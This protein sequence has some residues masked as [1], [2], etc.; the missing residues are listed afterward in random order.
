MAVPRLRRRR[1][2]R[3]P[4][5][6]PGHP[7]RSDRRRP[8]MELK[9]TLHINF[10]T[11][12]AAIK[13][14]FKPE[15]EKAAAFIR[16]HANVPYVVISGYTDSQ[17]PSPTINS[18]RNVAPSSPPELI[19]NYGV[20]ESKIR[21]KGFGESNPIADNGTPEG[22]SQN[23]RVEVSC[24]SVLPPITRL[25]K[26]EGPSFRGPSVTLCGTQNAF[27]KPALSKI[28]GRSLNTCL[29][30]G[31]T[32]TWGQSSKSPLLTRTRIMSSAE[33][34]SCGNDGCYARHRPE[35]NDDWLLPSFPHIAMDR[36]LAAKIDL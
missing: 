25:K 15:L 33:I 1:C 26:T 5:Q 7:E 36:I 19:K 17:G 3:L 22:R 28:K 30:A 9:L 23:R 6:M 16:A 34:L 12:Q 35:C 27:P 24:C 18:F 13:P 20:D 11:N 21:S 29:M 32:N 8:G 2:P 14:E 4:G 10:D 31:P